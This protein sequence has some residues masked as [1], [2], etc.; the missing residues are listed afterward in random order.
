MAKLALV[1][2]PTF[3]LPVPIPVPGK[4]PVNVEFKFKA[5]TKTAFKEFMETIT[6]GN[7]HDDVDVVMDVACG[8]EQDEPFERDNVAKLL[9]SYLGASRAIIEAYIS[10]MTAARQKN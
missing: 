1:L 2:S 10:E 7:P 6:D 4:K 3:T 8:W 5:R 9:D